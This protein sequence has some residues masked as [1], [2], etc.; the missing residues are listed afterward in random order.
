MTNDEAYTTVSK[1]CLAWGRR[2]AR[3]ANLP[4]LHLA[5]SRPAFPNPLAWLARRFFAP[6]PPPEPFLTGGQVAE[7]VATLTSAG[8]LLETLSC[9]TKPS[10]SPR[11]SSTPPYS[12]PSAGPSPRG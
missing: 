9:P 11:T 3:A 6:P 4:E 5:E 7:L 1:D 10:T 2:L 12:P 8:N